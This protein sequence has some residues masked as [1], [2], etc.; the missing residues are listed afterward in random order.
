MSTHAAPAGKSCRHRGRVASGGL[1]QSYQNFSRETFWYDWG[2]ESYKPAYIARAE[3]CAIT[4]KAKHGPRFL[5]HPAGQLV[6]RWEQA[7]SDRQPIGCS[8]FGTGFWHAPKT[9]KPLYARFGNDFDDTAF[10][11]RS[12]QLAC[13]VQITYVGTC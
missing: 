5:M 4:Q 1:N 3:K 11:V 12:T 6:A 8:L 10:A 2:R 9:S 7:N 13:R